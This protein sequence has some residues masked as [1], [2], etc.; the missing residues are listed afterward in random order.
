M[1]FLDQ[2]YRQEAPL[3]HKTLEDNRNANRKYWLQ[4]E[5]DLVEIG[6]EPEKWEEIKGAAADKQHWAQIMR[7]FR[8]HILPSRSQKESAANANNLNSNP[9]NVE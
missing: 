8:E 7:S 6:L 1:A 9:D 5:K 3:L 4:V 2:V